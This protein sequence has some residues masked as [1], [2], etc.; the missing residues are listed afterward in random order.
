MECDA[1]QY[2]TTCVYLFQCL[3]VGCIIGALVFAGHV[4]IASHAGDHN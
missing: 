3:G 4:I 2:N 1:N